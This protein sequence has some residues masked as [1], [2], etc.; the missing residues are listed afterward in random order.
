MRMLKVSVLP[1]LAV[2]LC[3]ACL[4]TNTGCSLLHWGGE[5]AARTPGVHVY[6]ATILGTEEAEFTA[7]GGASAQKIQWTKDPN[8][9]E[10]QL[11]I[12][13]IKFSADV[14]GVL[15]MLPAILALIPDIQEVQ[16]HYVKAAGEAL[17][18][19]TDS[20]MSGLVGMTA[21]KVAVT[22]LGKPA[23][24]LPDGIDPATA[25]TQIKAAYDALVKIKALKEPPAVDL[26]PVI[27][28]LQN[29]VS[30]TSTTQP[31]TPAKVTP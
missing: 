30:K 25:I 12:D 15:A 1:L 22:S 9:G 23:I 7:N 28:T 18:S 21:A 19:V 26:Q 24:E 3:G 31:A 27:S 13:D 11:N 6:R 5:N 29:I 8:T 20:V 17:A 14:S 16:V 2:F 4:L 10:F